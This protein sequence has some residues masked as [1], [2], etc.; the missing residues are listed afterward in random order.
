M[1]RKLSRVVNVELKNLLKYFLEITFGMYKK[2]T[3]GNNNMEHLFSPPLSFAPPQ[4]VEGFFW[5]AIK[6]A[7][8]FRRSPLK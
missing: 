4:P 2:E 1:A 6:F 8:F 7:G 5:R 3:G